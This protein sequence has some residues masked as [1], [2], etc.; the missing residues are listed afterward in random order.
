MT[1]LSHNSIV[2]SQPKNSN[3]SQPKAL[4]VQRA[5]V[6]IRKVIRSFP[7]HDAAVAQA[8][9][10]AHSTDLVRCAKVLYDSA[11]AQILEALE[12]I[13]NRKAYWQYQRDHQWL[14]FLSKNPIKWVTGQSQSVEIQ[15]NI[16]QLESHQGELYV[17]LGQLLEHGN[18]FVQ[19]Y[20]TFF[21]TDYTKGYGWIDRLLDLLSR[22]KVPDYAQDENSSF[23]ARALLLQLKLEGVAYFKIDILSDIKDTQVPSRFERNW[24]KYGTLALGLSLGYNA[25]GIEKLKT[26]FDYLVKEADQYIVKPIQDVMQDIFVPGSNKGGP[27]ELSLV[28]EEDIDVAKNSVKTFLSGLKLK[29]DYGYGRQWRGDVYKKDIEGIVDEKTGDIDMAKLQALAD[30]LTGYTDLKSHALATKLWAILRVLQIGRQVGSQMQGQL[31]DIQKQYAGVG[32]IAF[33]TPAIF[34]GLLA[35]GGYQKF[36]T[37]DYS[38]IRRALLDINSLFV[39]QTK[40]LDD[41]SYGKMVYLLYNLKK[42]AKKDLPQKNNVQDDFLQD[43]EK[44]ESKEFDVA[45]K[46]RIVDDMFKKYSFLGSV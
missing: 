30:T 33:L 31:T 35:Y 27:A 5:L 7:V 18:L 17:L 3:Q 23:M 20:K 43:L 44:V 13:D 41:E 45:A 39:D 46:R 26:S 38:L 6:Y 16:E 19:G 32:K 40:P 42:R 36:S 4:T 9:E 15:N 21:L 28:S 37:R 11:R 2:S 24:F 25:G 12:E 14:Y 34:T 10:K 8:Y 22:V 1:V 29:D